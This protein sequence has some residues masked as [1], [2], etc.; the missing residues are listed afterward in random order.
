MSHEP[1][2]WR[3][4][5]SLA[6]GGLGELLAHA[7]PTMPPPRAVDSRM[8]ARVAVLAAGGAALT[9]AAAMGATKALGWKLA[10]TIVSAATV[11][12]VVGVLVARD[13]TTPVAAPPAPAPVVAEE[14]AP[15]PAPVAPVVAPV[16]QAPPRP[17]A[18]RAAPRAAAPPR[19]PAP[20]PEETLSREAALLEEAR[21]L[22]RT[23]PGAALR[24]VAEHERLFRQAVLV[25]EREL[26]AVEALARLGRPT[27]ARR[28]ARALLAR[29]PGTLYEERVERILGGK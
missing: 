21:A 4:D 18:P 24:K 1:R 20:S 13:R 7:R 9:D 6:P 8:A 14:P 19:P 11:A 27:D 16:P 15:T 12:S 22:V 28:R 5:P 25:P 26:I 23:S 2:R 17:P 10:A 29:H 3:D